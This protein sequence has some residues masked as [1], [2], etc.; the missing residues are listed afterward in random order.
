MIHLLFTNGVFSILLWILVIAIISRLF[1]RR[2]R[3]YSY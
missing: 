1:R 2:P 3:R